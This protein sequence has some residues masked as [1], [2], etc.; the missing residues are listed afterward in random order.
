MQLKSIVA[1]AFLASALSF[2][3]MAQDTDRYTMEKSDNGYVRMDRKTGEMSICEERSGQLVCKLAA[4]ERS[5]FQDEVDRLQDRLSGLEKRVAEIETASRL[6][7]NALL[8]DEESFEKSL[9]YMERFFR[10]FMDIVRDL[11]Q[12]WRKGEPDPMPQKT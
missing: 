12:D 7:P 10:R 2:P 5:A 1:S 9:G 3:A 6:N 4:D 11:D 8:P